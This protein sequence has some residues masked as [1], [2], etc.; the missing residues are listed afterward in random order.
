MEILLD[1]CVWVEDVVG[2]GKEV[3]WIRV[4]SIGKVGGGHAYLEEGVALVLSQF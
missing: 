1:A 3:G 4:L 2:F